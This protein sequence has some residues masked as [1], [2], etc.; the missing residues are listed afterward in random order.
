MADAPRIRLSV[1][2]M[3]DE[4]RRAVLAVLESGQLAQGPRVREFEEAFASMCGVR[5]AVAVSSGTAALVVALLAHG[6]GADDEVITTPFSFVASANAVLL[7]GARPVFVDVR[8]GDFNIDPALIESRITPR[9]KALLP[10]HLFGHPCDMGAIVELADRHD[11]TLVE[12]ASQ[13]VGASVA[14]R[15]VGG[16]GTGCFSFYATKNV[17]TGEG[18]MITTDD[19]ALAEKAR[20]IRD[21]GQVERY[22]SES[23]GY[24]FRMTEMAAALGLAQLAKLE[25]FTEARRANAGHLSEGLRGVATPGERSGCRHVYH[26][27]TVRVATGRDELAARLRE[28]G[29]ETGVFYRTPIHRQPLYRRLGYEEGLPVAE[30]LSGEVL[31]LPV[32]PGLSQADLDAVVAAVNRSAVAAGGNRD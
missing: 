6:I 13:A 2:L 4:E 11:L 30:R 15:R 12:D 28:E 21:H 23:L 32:H 26:Q 29:I 19:P 8:E 24:N 1:P 9:T 25:T 5:E 31:S 3:G 18:G 16:F 7:A 20:R 14:G 22:E 17:T 10:V 27:Y